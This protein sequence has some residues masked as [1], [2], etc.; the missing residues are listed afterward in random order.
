MWD[1]SVYPDAHKFDG[2]RFLKIREQAGQEYAAQLVSTSPEH[3]GFGYGKA[4]CPGR[5][6]AAKELKITLCHI[7]LKYDIKLATG[8]HPKAFSQGFFYVADPIAKIAVRRR[9]AEIDL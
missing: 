7:L 4:A 5:F 8:S 6:F 9:K 1:S 2:Y 3:L